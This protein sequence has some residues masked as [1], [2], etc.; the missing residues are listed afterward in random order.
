MKAKIEQQ[1]SFNRTITTGWKDQVTDSRGSF[2]RWSFKQ[3]AARRSVALLM[4]LLLI[5]LWWVSNRKDEEKRGGGALKDLPVHFA[6]A[7]TASRL[8]DHCRL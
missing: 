5:C 8:L 3:F 4:A 7:N 1:S 6:K 2:N